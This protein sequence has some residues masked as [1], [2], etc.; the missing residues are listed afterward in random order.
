MPMRTVSSADALLADVP[1]RWSFEGRLAVSNGKDSGSGRIH[2]QQD[3]EFFSISL[4]APISGQ[5]W[6]LSGDSS[7]AQ[8]EG[9]RPYAVL[10]TSARELLH[11]ELGWELPV[12]EMTAWLFGRG[13]GAKA[14][15]E[16]E[17][18]GTLALVNDEGW[19]IAYRNWQ[20]IEGIAVPS[21]IVAKN[22][23][24]Q[25]RLAIQSWNLKQAEVDG[26]RR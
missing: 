18:S 8:L 3:G 16:H 20:Q 17:P 14:L 11:R 4:R 1:T 7:H 6:L 9:V 10:G 19:N 23:P 5:S 15:L 24:Y 13:F 26:A 2:W 25:V 21:R 12:G 22:A